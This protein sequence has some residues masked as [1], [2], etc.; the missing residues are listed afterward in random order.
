MAAKSGWRGCQM[1]V[2]LKIRPVP[3]SS[4]HSVSWCWQGKQ[5][6][7]GGKRTVPQLVQRG[8]AR[9]SSLAASQN[10]CVRGSEWVSFKILGKTPLVRGPKV[11]IVGL[12][13][14]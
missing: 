14:S 7:D 13:F 10:G 9:R 4:T 12:T 1:T 11:L 6:A 2:K 8:A 3:A 5:Y